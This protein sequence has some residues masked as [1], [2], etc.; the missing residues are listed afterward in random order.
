MR[1]QHR[2]V[3]RGAAQRTS[4]DR[5]ARAERVRQVFELRRSGAA[6]PRQWLNTK[7]PP[8]GTDGH[9]PAPSKTSPLRLWA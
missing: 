1:C 8:R 5:I 4:P 7:N 6:L 9:Q 2:P 3:P